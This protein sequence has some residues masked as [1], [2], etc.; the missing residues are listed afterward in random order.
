MKIK[1]VGSTVGNGA[2][3]HFASSY[4]IN[5]TVVIDAGT[6]GLVSPLAVQRGIRHVLLSHSHIDHVGTLP[7]FLDNVH[8]P[9]ESCPTIYASQ[10]VLDSLQ[11]DLFND[12]VWPDLMRL[13]QTESPFLTLQ[14]ITANEP[15]KFADLSITPIELDHVVPTLGFIVADEKS[16]VAIVS[17]TAPT[18]RVWEF[19]RELPNLQAVFL[20]VAFPDALAWLADKSKHLTPATFA[21]ELQKLRRPVRTIAVHIKPA[22]HSQVVAELKTL[23][24]AHVEVGVPE[25]CYT[26]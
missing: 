11:Q 22:F 12:R 3:H 25:T 16:A 26:F 10:F 8:E 23:G 2:Q 14:A 9:G 4:I 20:E 13:S 1:L 7:L 17:D 5:D 18:E 21:A 24:L 15:V 19:A 6:I